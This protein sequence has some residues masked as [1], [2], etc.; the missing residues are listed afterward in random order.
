MLSG[1]G[2]EVAGLHRSGTGPLQLLAQRVVVLDQAIQS[3][4][5]FP[6][7]RDDAVAV[8]AVLDLA[9][10]DLLDGPAD[11]LRHRALFGFGMSPRGPRTGPSGPRPSSDLGL[12]RLRRVHKALI[13]D[14]WTRGHPSRRRRPPTPRPPWPSRPRRRLRTLRVLPVRSAASACPA[15]SGQ[16][17]RVYVQVGVGL[18]AL[19]ELRL[20]GPSVDPAPRAACSVCSDLSSTSVQAASTIDRKSP[21]SWPYPPRSS[22]RPRCQRR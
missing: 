9:A 1:H 7:N 22:T 10:F 6:I 18:D 21:C 13:L 3:K 14:G 20:P 11:V 4:E 19:V 16:R 8:D 17:P 5:F 12:R 2:L 15:P